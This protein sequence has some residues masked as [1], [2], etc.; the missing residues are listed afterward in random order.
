MLHTQSIFPP[1]SLSIP[2]AINFARGFDIAILGLSDGK[3]LTLKQVEKT[4]LFYTS[5][6]RGAVYPKAG[7][8][9]EGVW[10]YKYEN[11]PE[12]V[13]GR[14]QLVPL[15]QAHVQKQKKHCRL[16]TYLETSGKQNFYNFIHKTVKHGE[17]LPTLPPNSKPP[18]QE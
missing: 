14:V 13:T 17:A 2:E 9:C 12:T 10:L 11:K 15:V 3:K 6:F 8:F 4:K 7:I 18:P 16:L 5:R 1:P